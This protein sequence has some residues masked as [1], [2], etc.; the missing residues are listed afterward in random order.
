MFKASSGITSHHDVLDLFSTCRWFNVPFVMKAGKA[1]NERKT[2]VRIQYKPP[3]A[4]IHG[5]AEAQRNE[6][7]VCSDSLGSLCSQDCTF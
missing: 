7:V 1:L 5:D 3:T 2:E 6:L 4:P